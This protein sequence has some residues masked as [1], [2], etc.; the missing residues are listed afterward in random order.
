M[1]IQE[2]SEILL[3]DGSYMPRLGQ[4]T[5]QMGEDDEHYHREVEGLRYG[6]QEGIRMLDTAE[7]YADGKAENITGNAIQRFLS[8]GSVCGQQS[9]SAECQ[10]PSDLQQ[11][12]T[13]AETAWYGL[14]GS[15]SA[16]LA[17]GCRSGRSG[18]LHGRSETAGQ[19]PS[20][21]CFQF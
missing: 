4:G 8:G 2:Q 11:S 1:R 10:P 18:V 21:G 20:L 19:N 3:P 6:I 9:L 14:S 7:M 17:G 5:W 12:G 15:V 13:F 16:A